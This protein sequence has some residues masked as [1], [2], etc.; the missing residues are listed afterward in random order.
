MYYTYLTKLTR[1]S[2][3]AIANSRLYSGPFRLLF[4]RMSFA[5]YI[6]ASFFFG[7]TVTR[8]CKF[9]TTKKRSYYVSALLFF[10]FYEEKKYIPS[11]DRKNKDNQVY[12][13]NTME[14][15]Y[16]ITAYY[17]LSR[18]LSTNP[19]QNSHRHLPW[20]HELLAFLGAGQRWLLRR[21]AQNWIYKIELDKKVHAVLSFCKNISAS[22]VK[23]LT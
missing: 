17:S 6:M 13:L 10:N 22:I 19:L 15:Q 11:N 21:S 5:K 14:K 9:K 1:A 8:I 16:T 12:L 2:G 20:S 18:Y 7:F 23:K 4:C 3:N